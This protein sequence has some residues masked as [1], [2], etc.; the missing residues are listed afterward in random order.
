ML[1][2]LLAA[3]GDFF[4][5]LPSRFRKIDTNSC[6]D[7]KTYT[8]EKIATLKSTSKNNKSANSEK[9][10]RKWSHGDSLCEIARTANNYYDDEQLVLGDAFLNKADELLKSARGHLIDTEVYA[11]QEEISRASANRPDC[12]VRLI[13]KNIAEIFQTDPNFRSFKRAGQIDF[14]VDAYT[15][16]V[17]AGEF[18]PGKQH[19]F[20]VGW[21]CEEYIVVEVPRG[22]VDDDM[23]EEIEDGAIQAAFNLV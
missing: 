9:S 17:W 14:L 15:G 6:S 13:G 11:L 3:D 18:M 4:Q 19:G 10:F 5:I 1:E 8:M 22:K 21:F 23:I 7:Y 12:V 16:E 2:H 20:H